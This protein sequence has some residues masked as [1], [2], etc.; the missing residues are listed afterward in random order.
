MREQTLE[1]LEPMTRAARMSEGH[2][3]GI[4]AHW[5]RGLTTDLM[6][7]LNSMFADGKQKARGY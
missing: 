1:L 4:L 2:L 6:E 3:A 7:G 5:N